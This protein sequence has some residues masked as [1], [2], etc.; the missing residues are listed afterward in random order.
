MGVRGGGASHQVQDL[1]CTAFMANR[2]V[3]SLQVHRRADHRPRA[4]ARQCSWA[5][6]AIKE[7]DMRESD[8]PTAVG[9]PSS[10]PGRRVEE[11]AVVRLREAPAH[12][13]V[14]RG[15]GHALPFDSS[16]CEPISSRECPSGAGTDGRL[17]GEDVGAVGKEGKQGPIESQQRGGARFVLATPGSFGSQVRSACG[18]GSG[19]VAI[20]DPT[21]M[22]KR[23][24]FHASGG[25]VFS[26]E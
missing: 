10:K 14:L 15:R 9:M 5:R 19:A 11:R 12:P 13:C 8:P 20:G 24:S 25:C 21:G 16:H 17:Q 1:Q 6:G 22:G 2:S 23:W 26:L 7:T 4:V 18:H 3:R